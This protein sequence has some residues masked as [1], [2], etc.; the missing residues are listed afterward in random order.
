[1]TD[2]Y[3]TGAACR[4]GHVAP[5]YVKGGRCVECKAEK[6]RRNY[7]RHTDARIQKSAE[8][9]AANRNASMATKREYHARKKDDPGYQAARRTYAETNAEHLRRKKREYHANPA[10]KAAKAAKKRALAHVYLSYEQ[11]RRASAAQAVPGW[12]GE[13]DEFVIREAAE[14]CKLRKRATGIGWQVDHLIALLCKVACGLHCASNIQVI[15]RTLNAR[16][17]NK[18]ELTQPLEW[19]SHI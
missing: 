8:W 15:P 7:A 16:K 2:T 3:F 12:Y 14:L 18:F 4:N 6:D 19:L 9:Y 13:L 17:N 5:R 1:M 10:N 11:K